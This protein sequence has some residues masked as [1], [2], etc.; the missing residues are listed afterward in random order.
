MIWWE[1]LKDRSQGRT[2][3]GWWVRF[4]LNSRV[5]DIWFEVYMN[6]QPSRAVDSL[7][8]RGCRINHFFTLNTIY[9]DPCLTR[10]LAILRYR[11][12]DIDEH[13]T[14]CIHQ[15]YVTVMD[16]LCSSEAF[17]SMT[18]HVHGRNQNDT[19]M[20][21]LNVQVQVLSDCREWNWKTSAFNHWSALRY[22]LLC[23]DGPKS[24]SSVWS[25]HN[26]TGSCQHRER[27]QRL[28]NA[29]KAFHAATRR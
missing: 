19:S 13:I 26:D 8:N 6:R 1:D 23:V 11:V 14:K 24:S 9:W 5:F 15:Q 4:T 20:G 29:V 21:T 3:T 22:V 17:A 18:C 27:E 25:I 16:R 12:M 10:C 28:D 2:I 7:V